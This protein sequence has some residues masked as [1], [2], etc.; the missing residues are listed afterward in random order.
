GYFTLLWPVSFGENWY[1]KVYAGHSLNEE[2]KGK[3]LQNQETQTRIE[4][5][6][7]DMAMDAARNAERSVRTQ[8]QVPPMPS[9]A[10]DGSLMPGQENATSPGGIESKPA[11]IVVNEPGRRGQERGSI[12]ELGFSRTNDGGYVPVMSND[13]KQRYEE[14]IFGEIGWNLRNRLPGFIDRQDVAPPRSWLSDPDSSW[15]FD[16]SRGAWYERPAGRSKRSYWIPGM[17]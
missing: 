7:W 17:R 14:D 9:L 10:P 5:M 1:S 11:E 13:A 12:T 3:Q 2:L 15:E 16:L 8:Q 4:Q 6:K